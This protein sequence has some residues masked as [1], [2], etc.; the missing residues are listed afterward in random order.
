V[1]HRGRGGESGRVHVLGFD[2]EEEDEN[3]EEEGFII[4]TL[5]R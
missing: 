2:D 1:N 5:P 4:E 3:E